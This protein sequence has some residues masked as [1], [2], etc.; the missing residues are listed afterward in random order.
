MGIVYHKQHKTNVRT[1]DTRRRVECVAWYICSGGNV[2]CMMVACDEA[3][4]TD[5]GGGSGGGIRDGPV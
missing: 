5:S 3:R 1:L 4:I 2:N